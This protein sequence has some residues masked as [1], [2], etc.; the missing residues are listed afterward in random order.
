MTDVPEFFRAGD[1][2]RLTGLSLR[3]VRR[4]LADETL[5]SVKVGGTRLVA[6]KTLEQALSPSPSDVAEAE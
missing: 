4:R 3:T 5:A 2:A 6:R 1:I